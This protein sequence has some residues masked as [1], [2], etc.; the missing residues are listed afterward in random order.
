MGDILHFPRRTKFVGYAITLYTQEEI[1]VTIL[2]INSFAFGRYK[3]TEDTIDN[4]DPELVIRALFFMVSNKLFSKEA[5][6]ISKK[7]LSTV[8]EIPIYKTK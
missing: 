2:A 8:E 4:Y 5:R 6:E 3:V 7:I 1:D